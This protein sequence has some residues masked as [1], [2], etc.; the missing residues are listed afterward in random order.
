VDQFY[1]EEG[2]LE[3]S[4][5]TVIREA[6]SAV[7]ATA[8]LS[9][10][11]IIADATGY[12]IPDYIEVDYFVG[13]GATI[14]ATG[15]WSS[16]FTQTAQATR[17]QEVASSQSAAFTQSSLVG[18]QQS[19]VIDITSAFTPTLTVDAFKNHTAIL[20]VVA[21]MTSAGAVNR[22]A[23]VLLD[24]I[25]D[26]NAMAA[27]TVDPISTMA[28]TATQNTS[29]VKT[30]QASISLST[31]STVT[32][33]AL[34]IQFASAALSSNFTVFTSRYLGSGRP[35][36]L[37]AAGPFSSTA[38]YGSS[39]LQGGAT[40]QSPGL[41]TLPSPKAGQDWVYESYVYPTQSTVTASDILDFAGSLF[42]NVRILSNRTVQ[43]QLRVF[44]GGGSTVL[45]T[46]TSSAISVGA[47]HHITVVKN[48]TALSFY[49]D[50]TRVGTQVAYTGWDSYSNANI[51]FLTERGRDNLF[52]DES[53]VAYGTT[54]GHNP[55]NTTITV[56]TTAR[57]N[58]PATTQFLHHWEG[59]GVDDIT[60]QQLANI[61]LSTSATISAQAN[62]NTKQGLA[63]LNATA[64]VAATGTTLKE[65]ESTLTS[66][67]S[68]TAQ[69]DKFRQFQSDLESAATVTAVIGSVKQFN[70]SAGAL[71]TPSINVDAQLA[72][73]ALLESQFTQSLSAVKATDAVS[74]IQA[75]AS[76]S[77]TAT[78][79]AGLASALS[80]ATALS[81][82]A[83]RIQ[84]ASAALASEFAIIINN[85]AIEQYDASLSSEFACT[86]VADRF[87]RYSATLSSAF[88]Q[89]TQAQRTRDVNSALTSNTAIAATVIRQQQ[90]NSE[91]TSAFTQT[92]NGVKDTDVVMAIAVT[93]TQSTTAV[94]TVDAIPQLESIAT[95]LTAAFKNA[96]GTILL[97]STATVTA[98]VGQLVDL[99]LFSSGL[100]TST[101]S[102][103]IQLVP[104]QPYSPAMGSGGY[105][106]AFWAKRDTI[107]TGDYAYNMLAPTSFGNVSSQYQILQ[108]KNGSGP[109]SG[110]VS[111]S[112]AHSIT[113]FTPWNLQGNPYW[114]NTV[115]QDT[116]WHH[117]LI[118]YLPVSS[119]IGTL[120]QYT[121]YVDGISQGISNGANSLRVNSGFGVYFGSRFSSPNPTASLVD[122]DNFDGAM[123]QVWLGGVSVIDFAVDKFYNSGSVDLG[124]T[125]RGLDNQLPTPE[126]YN[127]LDQ[128]WLG[129]TTNSENTFLAASE[130][131]YNANVTARAT[132]VVGITTAVFLV[133]NQTVSTSLVCDAVKIIDPTLN[134]TAVSTFTVAI[135]QTIGIV[136]DLNTAFTLDAEVFRIKQFN[137][138][139]SAQASI[140]AIVGPI[141]QF[142]S[143]VSSEFTLEVDVLVKPPVRA[144]AFLLCTST[145]TVEVASFTDTTTLMFSLGTLT[146][147][148]T[149]IPPIR[150][151]ADLVAETAL[152]VIIGTIE[153]FAILT[154]SAGTMTVNAV[155]TAS[156]QGQLTARATV[157]CAPVKFTGIILTL[158]AF[159]TQLTVGD[160]VNL[161]PALTYVIPQETREYPIL[162]ENRLYEI[163]GETRLLIILQ[164]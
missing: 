49:V 146:A 83:T 67:F 127:L 55:S 150:I 13:G 65:A 46:A 103:E 61:T 157:I 28:A 94:K 106:M 82:T 42:L 116:R 78:V 139:L 122:A 21:T 163:A 105:V 56:P 104:P 93:A 39:S 62:A 137:S 38:K 112:Y 45:Y 52:L 115:P 24:H 29:A 142:N 86:V 75:V 33:L 113:F 98:V 140:T 114:D 153:Q 130:P 87:A 117:Y 124:P 14:D 53:S 156:A 121:L 20:E 160:V 70:I 147:D 152:S 41:T 123:A 101:G 159:N 71:F 50:G 36:T 37:T 59:N 102:Y 5:F 17:I 128:P 154:A 96:T 148:V 57:V 11:V 74:N 10:A 158:T 90:G 79:T 3:P 54:Y 76:Q 88:T 32:C 141:E 60:V 77:A 132:M 18:R 64:T 162:P 8:S 23:N 133:S 143:S 68:Q 58:D 26:L 125:G 108:F 27:K 110:G 135:T 89:D 44:A 99:G 144:E 138:T 131:L 30:S 66:A 136:S 2:Y 149:L 9:A 19:A 4:Y 151:E 72:G 40:T 12:Y 111:R 47:W 85:S 120:D 16:L 91:L 145:V 107:T 118:R 51:P 34:N 134:I 6:E 63:S 43:I 22:S 129:V 80:S 109:T 35:R 25:A 161:D 100:D 97:E 48:S 73:V 95:Q 155:K 15:E 92:A 1:F 69:I 7:T 119:G 84:Q 81:S 31:T 126:N 164:G